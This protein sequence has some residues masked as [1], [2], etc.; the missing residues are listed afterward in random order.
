MGFYVLLQFNRA[1]V[2]NCLRLVVDPAVSENFHY[3][4][5]EVLPISVFA[6]A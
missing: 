1:F 5:T 3:V 4:I 2:V 6:V